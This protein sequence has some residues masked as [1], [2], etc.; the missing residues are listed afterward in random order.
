MSTSIYN[1][2]FPDERVDGLDKV[3]GKARYTAEHEIPRM[4]YAVFICSTITKGSVKK[5]DTTN[6]LNIPG[7]LDVLHHENCPAVPGY[8]PSAFA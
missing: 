2:Q 8:K 3:T 1:F 4:A 5:I 6:A 7:A